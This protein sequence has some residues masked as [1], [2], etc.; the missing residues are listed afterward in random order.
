MKYSDLINYVKF[1]VHPNKEKIKEK[2][3][4]RYAEKRKRKTAW[5]C[6]TVF[7]ITLLSTG[8]LSRI[9]L[10]PLGNESD[11][12]NYLENSSPI[13]SVKPEK[14]YSTNIIPTD[15]SFKVVTNKAISKNEFREIFNIEPKVNYNVTKE[16]G[17]TFNVNFISPLTS[18]TLYTIKSMS[19]SKTAYSWAYQTE[20][21]FEIT[22]VYPSTEQASIN[23]NIYVDFSHT[24]VENFEENFS[25]Y[26]AVSGTF[27]HYKNRW[28]FIPS[29]EL[30]KD[31]LYT[32]TLNRSIC[33]SNEKALKKDVSFSFF[34]NIVDSD[35]SLN[36]SNEDM[37][38]TFRLE[39]V[40]AVSF[41]YKD[42]IP[43]TADVDV[44]RISTP[45]EF[46]KLHKDH[47]SY[48][49]VSKALGNSLESYDKVYSF[50]CDVKSESGTGS[51]RYEEPL[52]AGFYVSKI[53]FGQTELYQFIQMNDL[54][55]Y[56]I[57]YGKNHTVWINNSISGL[58]AENAQVVLGPSESVYA[59]KS[60]IAS[61]E[62]NNENLDYEYLTIRGSDT[63][64]FVKKLPPSHSD[65]NESNSQFDSFIKTDNSVYSPGENVKV[66]GFISPVSKDAELFKTLMAFPGWSNNP[67]PISVSENGSFEFEV[68]VPKTVKHKSYSL[69]IKSDDYLIDETEI[70]V[71]EKAFAKYDITCTTDKNE[72]FNGDNVTFSVFVSDKNGVPC[73]NFSIITDTGETV[74]T[75]NNGKA[76]FSKQ[77]VCNNS[78]TMITE[79]NVIDE[80]NTSINYRHSTTVYPGEIKLNVAQHDNKISVDV[81]STKTNQ[82]CNVELNVELHRISFERNVKSSVYDPYRDTD[83]VSYTFE[84]NDEII[85]EN[86][87]ETTNGNCTF[88]IQESS[89]RN[90]KLYYKITATTPNEQTVSTEY[91]IFNNFDLNADSPYVFSTNSESYNTGDAVHISVHKDGLRLTNGTLLLSIVSKNRITNKVYTELNEIKQDLTNDFFGDVYI[92]GAYFD[93]ED[94]H[95]I[96]SL[97]IN[98]RSPEISIDVIPEKDNYS[99]GET[100][101]A[102]IV[103]K[104]NNGNAIS[105]V[106]NINVIDENASVHGK[107]SYINFEDLTKTSSSKFTITQKESKSFQIESGSETD[108][109][110]YLIDSPLFHSIVT[111]KNGNA[112]FSF[113]LPEISTNWNISATAHAKNIFGETEY[114]LH[115]K[116]AF[117]IIAFNNNRITVIDECTIPFRLS[118]TDKTADECFYNAVLYKNNAIINEYSGTAEGNSLITHSFGTLE[119]GDYKLR[120]SA[121]SGQM[122]AAKD[123]EF[124]IDD[125]ISFTETIDKQYIDDE[126]TIEDKQYISDSKITIYDESIDIYYSIAEKLSALPSSNILN[127]PSKAF[128]NGN[129]FE[130]FDI[131][132]LNYIQSN[133]IK[134]Q[135]LF[136]A[137]FNDHFDFDSVNE[138]LTESLYTAND[139]L[140][141]IC[142]YLA[143]ASF[144]EPV[145][146]ELYKY[147]ENIETLNIEEKIYLALAFAYAGDFSASNTIYN[148]YVMPK[149]ISA[150]G[151]AHFDYEGTTDEM[152]YLTALITHLCGKISVPIGKEI[153]KSLLIE[154]TA[155]DKYSLELYTFI[156]NH[157]PH[158][159]GENE[160]SLDYS[161]GSSQ[162]Y[163]FNKTQALCIDVP[164]DKINDLIFTSINGENVVLIHSKSISD[165]SFDS[166]VSFEIDN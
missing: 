9:R 55:V 39:T 132:D 162:K 127:K 33:N 34:S 64:V 50:T 15:T 165:S 68:T 12:P 37:I 112:S 148:D 7:C 163:K 17:N 117:N 57:S 160:I 114:K 90:V 119:S 81:I 43:S 25:I 47:T 88:K 30:E 153:T 134:K 74:S 156:I 45:E 140:S 93:G 69:E 72:Y 161:D 146:N 52:D 136:Y 115:A 131:E 144:N 3:Y 99:P 126:F 48:P 86:I 13:K 123:F 141:T 27:E 125:N 103:T 51:F 113:E 85:S 143:L 40:P 147:Y 62:A 94:I 65:L 133:D 18:D 10:L 26:P 149:I 155:I 6:V 150:N 70:I 24:D 20:A 60:G 21:D 2:I 63:S 154:E 41:T 61:F 124:S 101:N 78:D 106:V 5:L 97:K 54:S 145:L 130:G 102:K 87:L 122:T 38:D 71:S 135:A 19:G 80:N 84:Q 4:K 107:A 42:S 23:T 31:V 8:A 120:I 159:T 105:A 1:T 108:T 111:D 29:T 76:T 142:C 157:I 66:F 116:E 75:N 151:V 35:I 121:K 95:Q 44:Y 53:R 92:H 49:Y 129:N 67:V 59:D 152:T 82:P 32:V 98:V 58:P 89:F 79:F 36:Y 46:I 16:N 109:I 104:D 56:T 91:H 11:L 138:S 77:A 83:Q 110:P 100:V 166:S 28:I 137:V 158:I 128:L 118:V 22:S 96:K 14:S 139:E 164:K 73:K